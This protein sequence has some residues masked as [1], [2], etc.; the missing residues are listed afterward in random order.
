MRLNRSET[1]IIELMTEQDLDRVLLIEGS[2]FPHSWSRQSFESEIGR[3]H[4]A[5][6]RVARLQGQVVGYG[7][8]WVILDEAHLTTLA[9]DQPHRGQGIATALLSELMDSA[10]RLG[11]NKMTLEVRPSNLVARHLY[12]QFGFMVKGVRKKYYLDEDALL[13]TRDEL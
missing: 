13:M 11:A 4:L 7:G 12:E 2:S 8:I 1:L 6:Y 10:R 9:V 3:N 5:E